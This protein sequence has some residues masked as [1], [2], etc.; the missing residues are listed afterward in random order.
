MDQRADITRDGFVNTA[1]IAA[2]IDRL[3][4]VGCE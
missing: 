3:S 4:G 2:Y 1:D